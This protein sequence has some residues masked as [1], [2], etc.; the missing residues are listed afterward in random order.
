MNTKI[1]RRIDDLGR[2]VIPKEIRDNLNINEGE[3]LEISVNNDAILLSKY[4]KIKNVE[5]Y[6]IKACTIISNIFE[7][8]IILT[9]REKVILE[10]PN[11]NNITC[12]NIS[13]K[14]FAYYQNKEEYNKSLT[15]TDTYSIYENYKYKPIIKNS[16]YIG[17]IIIIGNNLELNEKL[18]SLILSL[19][20]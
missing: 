10:I 15:I 20:D 17:N 8:Y 7:V 16:D 14:M 19:L 2:I 4:S 13:P 6:L 18:I 12:Q 1:T 9:D 3:N 11:K 5:E